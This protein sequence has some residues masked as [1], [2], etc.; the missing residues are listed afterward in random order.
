M[1]SPTL[2]P[3]AIMKLE[4]TLISSVAV[5]LLLLPAAA[6]AEVLDAAAAGFTS[7]NVAEISAPPERVW[8]AL[9]R[10]LPSW[11][12][13]DHTFSA[14]S[15]NLSLEAEAQ[16]CLCERLP[17]GGSV[18]HMEIVF[19][20]TRERLVMKGGLGPLQ[21]IGAGGAMNWVLSSDGSA[22]DPATLLEL[23]YHVAGYLPDGLAGWAAPVDGVLADQLQ[24]LER[25]IETGQPN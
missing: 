4:A 1:R 14:D 3:G 25:Y 21:Q 8:E 18:R 12:H 9:T 16:G 24:R 23:T 22:D 15:S 19:V 6:S 11:W 17:D 7:R 20:Q 13:P 10:E 2:E 5:V